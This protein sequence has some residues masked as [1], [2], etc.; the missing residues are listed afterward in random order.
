MIRYSSLSARAR[1]L[2]GY[3][4][5]EED[6]HRLLLA[7]DLDALTDAIFETH[8][9]RNVSPPESPTLPNLELLFDEVVVGEYEKFVSLASGAGRK[10]LAELLRRF[11]LDNL[12]AILRQRAGGRT[13]AADAV[14]VP[15]RDTVLPIERLQQADSLRAIA[16]LLSNTIYGP[17]L[18]DALPRYES[19]GT[20]FPVEVALDLHHWR[21][22]WQA[23]RAL[24]GIDLDQAKRLIGTRLDRLNVTWA[25]RYR[26]YYDLSV[27]EIINYTLP[28]GYRSD[29]STV[30][31][32]ASGANVQ[33]VIARVWGEGAPEFAEVP[34]EPT[35][36]SLQA[37]ETALL[38]FEC[39]TAWDAFSGYPFHLGVVLGYL[40]LKECE[41]HDLATLAEAKA[42]GL[43]SE[44]VEPYLIASKAVTSRAAET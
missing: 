28:Y 36:E 21:S 8:Y 2:A 10:L 15:L 26:V 35:G 5:S 16:E 12:K 9:G 34:D 38:R 4:L 29:D 32:I 13:A 31:A 40:M 22:V 25:F 20:L 42:E 24:G 43:P 30:R 19:E 11:E 17:P 23:V 27:E 7:V 33:D 39:R 3:L 44:T 41:A 6:W 37:L 14:I 18:A 1:A